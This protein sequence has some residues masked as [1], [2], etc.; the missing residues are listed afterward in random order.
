MSGGAVELAVGLSRQLPAADVRA[1]AAAVQDGPNGV[2]E[3]LGRAAGVPIRSACRTLLGAALSGAERHV[4][5]GALLASLVPDLER[6]VLDVVWTGPE[7]A[8]ATSRLTSA[9]I[10]DLID[11]A[12]AEVMLVGY[13]VQTESSIAEAL[14]RAHERGVVVT[15]LLERHIDNS[16]FTGAA[17]V[18]PDLIATRLAWPAAHRPSGASLHAKILVVDRVAA[19]IGSA[20]VTGA[21]LQRNL[22]CG[23]LVRGGPE[24]AAIAGH[25][26][27]L[28]D[29]GE[30]VHIP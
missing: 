15:L 14:E 29:I 10:I 11:Q 1:L 17:I 22:E 13:A 27:S 12:H 6:A 26:R 4:V 19:L 28:I 30:V 18:F 7:S 8:L 25:L 2:Q 23:L 9:V 20:N 5:A 21:A 3:L 16:R 24:P